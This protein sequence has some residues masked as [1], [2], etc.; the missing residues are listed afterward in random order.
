MDGSPARFQLAV[1]DESGRPEVMAVAAQGRGGG[2]RIRRRVFRGLLGTLNAALESLQEIPG[3]GVIKEL[4]ASWRVRGRVSRGILCGE[5]APASTAGR[6]AAGCSRPLGRSVT[7]TEEMSRSDTLHTISRESPTVI[8]D[9]ERLNSPQW[10]RCY[11]RSRGI[12][13]SAWVP[14]R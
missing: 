13:S 11:E 7:A 2:G 4:K 14:V 5:C 1:L 8:V 10:G 6:R 3:V 9:S 12:G